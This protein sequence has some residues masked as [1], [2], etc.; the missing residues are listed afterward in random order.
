VE[1]ERWRRVEQLYHSALKIAAEQRATFLKVECQDDE[2]LREEVESLLSYE[3][4]AAEF[5]ESPAFDVAARL[6]AEDQ[7]NEPDVGLAPGTTLPR[8]R[9]LEKLGGGGMGIVY[10]AE[11][12]K[13][14]R[15]VALKFLPPELS[16]DPQALERFQR[17]AYAASALNHPNIC[18][19]YDVDEYQDQPFI[20]MELL[21]GQTLECRIGEQGL[22]TT[23]LLQLGIQVSDALDAAHKKGIVHRD[24]K[25][26]NVFVTTRGQAKILDFGLAKRQES[27][28]GNVQPSAV[29]QPH[30]EE[31]WNPNVTLTRTGVTMGTAAYMSPEQVRGEKLDARTDLFS[32]GL[33]LYEMAAGQRAFAGEKAPIVQAA[34]LSKTPKPVRDLNPGIPPTLETIINKA[35]EKDREARYQFASE[36]R[37]DLETLKQQMERKGP[38]RWREIAAGVAVLLIASAILWFAK[39]QPPSFQTLPDLKVRQLTINSSENPVTNG[40]ISPDGKHLA[41]TDTIGIHVKLVETGE[42]QTVAQPDALKG[43][44]V[45]WENAA[46]FPDSTRFLANA[47][48]AGEDSSAWS[49]RTSSIWIVSLTGGAPRKLRDHAVAWAVSPD[50]SLVSF[51]TNKGRLGEREIWLMA[52]SGE[53]ARKLYDADEKSAICCLYFFPSGQRVS[54]IRTDE[55]GDALLG[56]D[57]KGGPVATLLPPSQMK[58]LTEGSWLPDGRFIYSATES[59]TVAANDTCN[60]WTMR[61]DSRTGQLIEKPRRLTNWA[62]FC[63]DNTSVTRDGKR[64]T[65]RKWEG[66][67]TAYLADLEAGG[68]GLRNPRRFAL[69]DS[70]DSLNDWTADSKTIILGSYRAGRLGIY[71]QSLN[72]DTPEPLMTGPTGARSPRVSPDNKWV[73]YLPFPS[74]PASSSE[75]EPLMRVPIT[76]GSPEPIF[77]VRPWSLSFCARPPSKLC[78]VAEATVDRK[79]MIVTAFDPVKGRGRELARFDLDPSEDNW[80]SD[81][82]YDGTRL[83]AIRGPHGPIYILSLRGQPTRVVEPKGLNNLVSLNWAADGRGLFVTNRIKGGTLLSHVDLQGNA[84]ALWKSN[85]GQENPGRPS[86]DGRYLAIQGWTA[87]SNMWMMENF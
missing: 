82:S 33:V 32:F 84:K 12:T 11:D 74:K 57:L 68:T 9:V 21:E 19:V 69:E 53:Q 31:E 85:G 62:G 65:F 87:N 64:L 6:M 60:Y 42:T 67:Q 29:G 56:R 7:A 86:P 80:L 24:I 59:E 43:E 16:H 1:P 71:K 78:A 8:F 10:K 51:G 75:L 50:G 4:S 2:E 36:M 28:T 72:E 18:T 25:P 63:M 66:H 76:G 73:I 38:G 70:S 46:W 44:Q 22:P 37:A 15:T 49:S 81:I 52:A 58:D 61:V 14:R 26:A 34:I 40:S 45:E 54:Y 30:L 17:E 41:Y 13:L 27:E 48:P 5:I 77:Q 35:L 3:S 83:A 47:H 39:H 79:Q 55:S 23:E 20:A